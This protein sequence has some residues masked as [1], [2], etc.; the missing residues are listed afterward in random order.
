[1]TE[2][3]K[4]IAQLIHHEGSGPVKHG[5]YLPYTDTVGKVTIGYGRN[6]TDRGLSAEE[7]LDLLAHDVDESIRD[8]A[9]FPWFVGLDPVRQRVLVDMRF[10]L[11]PSR[12]RKF[13][14]TL[15]AVE[16]HDFASAASHML[17]SLWA[18]Q[19]K[20]RAR[21]LARLMATGDDV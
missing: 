16:A 3:E 4:L 12:F 10:N 14:R 9:T 15:R 21:H 1:M 2:R 13:Q 5:R 6:L 18:R 8:C 17:D 7:A 19:V 11:G 20:G